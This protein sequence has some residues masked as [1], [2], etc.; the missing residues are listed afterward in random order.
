MNGHVV[1]LDRRSL[2]LGTRSCR[3]CA[4]ASTKSLSTELPGVTR[5]NSARAGAIGLGRS[6]GYDKVRLLPRH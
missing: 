5:A 2:Q 4:A 1:D 6:L 3:T